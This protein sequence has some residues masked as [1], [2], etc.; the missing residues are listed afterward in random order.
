MDI[1]KETLIKELKAQVES[2]SV[3]SK[4][5]DIVNTLFNLIMTHVN[6]GDTVNIPEFSV[7]SK[8]HRNHHR[9]S[10][11]SSHTGKHHSHSENKHRSK[12]TS[13]NYIINE[14]SLMLHDWSYLM[15]KIKMFTK[16]VIIVIT[17]L[18]TYY[19]LTVFAGC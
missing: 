15:N 18:L 17:F 12:K 13:S 3:S 6:K 2:G 19:L 11:H 5:P 4:T 7:H 1:S 14:L 10:T 16:K 8:S 9:D